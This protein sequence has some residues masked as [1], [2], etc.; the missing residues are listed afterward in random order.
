[1]ANL[2]TEMKQVVPYFSS[3]NP[4]NLQNRNS[5]DM[6]KA[7][8][9]CVYFRNFGPLFNKYEKH[10]GIRSII[11]AAGLQVRDKNR[12]VDK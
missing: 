10:Y 4:T 1:M 11:K 7:I 12:I 2:Q 6:L 3:A 5:C 8:E 9:A